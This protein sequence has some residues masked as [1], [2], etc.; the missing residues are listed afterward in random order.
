MKD[1]LIVV[2]FWVMVFA[3][4]I[5]AFNVGAHLEEEDPVRR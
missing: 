1:L 5:V 4:C 3:P 2:V